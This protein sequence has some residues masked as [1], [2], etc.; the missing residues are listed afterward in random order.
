MHGTSGE[1]ALEINR[2]SKVA[3]RMG[4]RL[5]IVSGMLVLQGRGALVVQPMPPTC[6][7]WQRFGDWELY[8]LLYTRSYQR[9]SMDYGKKK[10][11]AAKS[12]TREEIYAA[13]D[14]LEG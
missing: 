1:L 12:S 10:E 6:A 13:W 9:R 14:S 11:T 8:E 4:I 2:V 7:K 3:R 5:S